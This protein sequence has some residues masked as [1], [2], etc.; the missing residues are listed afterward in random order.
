MLACQGRVLEGLQPQEE[1][2]DRILPPWRC[3]RSPPSRI[4]LLS[5][6]YGHPTRAE[7]GWGR[8]DEL[9]LGFS[10]LKLETIAQA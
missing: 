4:P 1:P 9:S 2:S 5:A 8:E 10:G 6:E 3:K 7:Q